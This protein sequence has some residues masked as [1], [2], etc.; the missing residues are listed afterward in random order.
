MLLHGKD[1]VEG[2][3]LGTEK[4]DEWINEIVEIAISAL[5][6]QL[7]THEKVVGTL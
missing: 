4:R 7:E 2:P 1:A 3:Y 6:A 5:A